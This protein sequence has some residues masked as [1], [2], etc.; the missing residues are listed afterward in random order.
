MRIKPAET[1][2]TDEAWIA[3]EALADQEGYGDHTVDWFPWF[4]AFEKGYVTKMEG[5]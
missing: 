5:I 2:V 3:F 4:V 1:S